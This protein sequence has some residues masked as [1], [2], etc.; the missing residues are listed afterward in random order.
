MALQDSIL[1]LL[2]QHA[3]IATG[4]PQG[5]LVHKVRDLIASPNIDIR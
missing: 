4:I 1:M 2:I 3:R 5:E